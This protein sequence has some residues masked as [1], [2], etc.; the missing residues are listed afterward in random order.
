[1]T[2]LIIVIVVVLVVA[3]VAA[4][5]VNKRNKD[6]KIA[7]AEELRSQA[8]TQAQSTIAPAQQ[9]AAEAERRAEEARAQAQRAE[10]EAREAQVAA[11]QVEAEHEAQV[12]E[13]DQLDP[14]VDTR[15]DDYSPQVPGGVDQQPTPPSEVNRTPDPATTDSTDSTDSTGTTATATPADEHAAAPG[16]PQRTRGAQEMPGQ[17]IE[18]TDDG[19]GWFTKRDSSSDPDKA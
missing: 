18:K 5:L 11:Q 3:A 15:A 14:R 16:L 2:T 7:R 10:A 12:R 8:A 9:D 6:A 19:G 1:M 17:P 4:F 13:A